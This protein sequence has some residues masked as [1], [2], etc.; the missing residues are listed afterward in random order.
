[1][2]PVRDGDAILD[3]FR[4]ATVRATRV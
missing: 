2:A 3:E 4:S 1:M